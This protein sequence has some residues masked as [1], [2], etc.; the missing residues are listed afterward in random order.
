MFPFGKQYLS[1]RKSMKENWGVHTFPQMTS[2]VFVN[3]MYLE[4][5][6]CRLLIFQSE[7]KYFQGK[8]KKKRQGLPLNLEIEIL[9]SPIFNLSYT[10]I[11]G[12]LPYPTIILWERREAKLQSSYF[13]CWGTSQEPNKIK[14]K[15]TS[16]NNKIKKKKRLSLKQE[17]P[18]PTCRKARVF[19][20]AV[21][22]S[23]G[24]KTMARLYIFPQALLLS[25]QL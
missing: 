14:Q 20:W 13:T 11:A 15:P 25:L 18:T 21:S 4:W 5:A 10:K 8:K 2:I 9:A 22:D 17:T 19:G 16:T 23:S 1:K 6:A 24:G 12:G 7:V 3:T